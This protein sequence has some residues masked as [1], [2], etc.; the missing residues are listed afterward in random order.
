MTVI[1]DDGST[2][3]YISQAEARSRVDQGRA[4]WD[5]IALGFNYN[6][7]A[8]RMFAEVL[9]SNGRL[10]AWQKRPSG[11]YLERDISQSLPRGTKGMRGEMVMQLV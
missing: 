7:D 5:G 3:A 6:S 11:N 10:D 8:I 4:H 2:L 9:I 1:A